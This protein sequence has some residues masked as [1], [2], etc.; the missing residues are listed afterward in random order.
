MKNSRFGRIMIL[1]QK[2]VVQSFYSDKN[3]M[4][5]L[6]SAENLLIKTTNSRNEDI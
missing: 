5:D 4:S 1:K 2:T 6:H 3:S